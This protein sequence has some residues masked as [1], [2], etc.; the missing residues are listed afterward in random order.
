MA[1]S[2]ETS[3]ADLASRLGVDSE[4][5]E[6]VSVEEV[7]WRNGSLGCPQ[8][9]MFYTQALVDGLRIVLAVAGRGY[10]Y[11]QGGQGEPFLCERPDA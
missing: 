9:G 3:V 4:V 5:I 8:P 7:T 1:T 2:T 10:H 6:V 11:H